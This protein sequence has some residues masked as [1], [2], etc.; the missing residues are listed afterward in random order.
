MRWPLAW[1]STLESAERRAQD[2]A[3]AITHQ[4]RQ[5]RDLRGRIERAESDRDESD[6]LVKKCLNAIYEKDAQIAALTPKVEPPIKPAKRSEIDKV[7]REQAQGDARLARHLR[8]FDRENRLAGKTED[9]R[10]GLL[11]KW[12]TTE[13]T[14]TT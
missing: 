5:I 4:M 6:N 13:P 7:I 1:R 14:E 12:L 2:A 8:G 11:V 9:E 3:L 10:I